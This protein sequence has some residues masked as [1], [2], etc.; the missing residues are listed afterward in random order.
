MKPRRL[1]QTLM[2]A[3]LFGGCGQEERMNESKV[4]ESAVMR[5]YHGADGSLSAEREAE[6]WSCCGG[7]ELRVADSY[8]QGQRP[9]LWYDLELWVPA[10]SEVRGSVRARVGGRDHASVATPISSSG[11]PVGTRL[12]VR[13][14]RIDNS[15]ALAPLPPGEHE[16]EILFEL[17]V[18]QSGKKAFWART[19]RRAAARIRVV[20]GR[21]E[22]ERVPLADLE[23]LI[24]TELFAG[25]GGD[26][27]GAL[28]VG[29]S[30]PAPIALSYRAEIVRTERVDVVGQL[31]VAPGEAPSIVMPLP[32]LDPPLT[33]G[34]RVELR[35]T[36]STAE[37]EADPARF[38]PRVAADLIIRILV[39]DTPP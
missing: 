14:S 2:F 15:I 34:E 1:L 16:V 20:A 23:G 13:R 29:V 39:V 27:T 4:D 32:R 33:A 19:T 7:V 35:L 10:E 8:P 9:G 24:T 12:A 31:S 26:D 11:Y 25:R 37:V 21:T 3:A 36:P 30:R 28:V 18:R 22:P 38:G 17:D 5:I 6:L